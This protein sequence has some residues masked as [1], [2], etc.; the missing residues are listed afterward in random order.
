MPKTYLTSAHILNPLDY[1]SLEEW[2]VAIKMERYKDKFEE[3]GFKDINQIL[4]LTEA[5]L[6]AMGI[7]LSGH[8]YRIT[9]S[10]E[11]AQTQVS[12]QPSLKV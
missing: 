2:L 6:K 11:K 7:T 1:N 9:T 4:R 10:I 8:L 12:R 5:D 3:N